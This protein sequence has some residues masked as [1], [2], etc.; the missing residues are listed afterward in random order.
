LNHKKVKIC[1]KIENKNQ[2]KQENFSPNLKADKSKKKIKRSQEKK[3]ISQCIAFFG[4]LKKENCKKAK[5][6]RR[7]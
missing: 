7:K 4:W 3:E 6:G 1:Y 2:I 5:H